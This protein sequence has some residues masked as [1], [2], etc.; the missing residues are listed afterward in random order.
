[1]LARVPQTKKLGNTGLKLIW[2][3]SQL[4]QFR[5]S[6]FAMLILLER[7]L[8]ISTFGV[9]STKLFTI[10]T[11]ALLR[12]NFFYNFDN[13]LISTK[14]CFYNFDIC[15]FFFSFIFHLSNVHTKDN[16]GWTNNE[17][18][19]LIINRASCYVFHRIPINCSLRPFFFLALIII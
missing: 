11:F 13:F 8:P 18:I 19:K 17:N 12:Q 9:F 7:V 15:V 10:S 3:R 16:T 4:L 14:L 5:R 1:M 6:T 2:T